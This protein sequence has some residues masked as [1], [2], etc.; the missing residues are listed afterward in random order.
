M[1]TGIERWKEYFNDYKDKYVLIGG[2]ACNLLEEELDMNPRA[3][4]DLDIIL[5]VEA[6]TPDFGF[7]L[8]DFIKSANYVGRSR[9]DN[10]VKHEYYRFT[11]PEDKTYPKQIEL[12]AR[13]T[14]IL[15]LPPDAHIEPIS[16]GEDFSSLSAILMDDDYYAFT[17]EHSRN[18]ENIHV[19]NPEALICLK[20]KAYKEMLDKNAGLRALDAGRLL[21][22]F[23]TA[24]LK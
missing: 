11:N 1:V 7:R 16:V 20:A 18:I 13:N 8:W 17:I 14:G 3:T 21:D 4:K 2:A 24:F 10:E 9:G 6:I 19:A 23:N 15:N 5:V 12:F 22:L